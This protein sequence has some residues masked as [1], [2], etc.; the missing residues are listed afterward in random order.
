MAKK[1]S[2]NKSRPTL[3]AASLNFGAN[4]KPKKP[5]PKTGV[6]IHKGIAYGS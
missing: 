3:E 6:K 2:F 4:V 1:V 5:R